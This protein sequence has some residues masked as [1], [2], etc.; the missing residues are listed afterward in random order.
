MTRDTWKGMQYHQGYWGGSN[1]S[2]TKNTDNTIDTDTDTDN[3]DT[4]NNF[5]SRNI[6]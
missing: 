1:T 4:G 3:R 2:D 5:I 6:Q